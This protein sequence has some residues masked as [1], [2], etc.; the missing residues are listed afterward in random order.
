M[1]L[2]LI[3]SLSFFLFILSNAYTQDTISPNNADKFIGKN[4]VISGTVD[5]ITHTE[6]AI[7]LNMGGKFPNNSFVAVIFSK[8]FDAF[9][10]IDTFLEK[11]V[12]ISGTI[13]DFNGK[14]EII[15][16]SPSQ[17]KIK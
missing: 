4:V 9:K 11:E 7:Y 2:K 14:P 6:K 16:V 10:D 12:F 15:I 1:K 5:Q 8:N 3:F 13:K 17:L